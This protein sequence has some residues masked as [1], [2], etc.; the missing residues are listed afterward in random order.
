MEWLNDYRYYL[1]PVY[2]VVLFLLIILQ[3][4]ARTS[5]KNILHSFN[6]EID[7][8]LYK[9]TTMIYTHRATI[10]DYDNSLDLLYANRKKML[11]SEKKNYVEHFAGIKEDVQYLETLLGEPLADA[12]QLDSLEQT[13]TVLQQSRRVYYGIGGFVALLTLG[14]Y[15]LREPKLWR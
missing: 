1:V 9:I 11:A 14:L 7:A 3:Q 5:Q 13:R 15:K 8:L 4:K 6:R 2:L 12:T 10:H